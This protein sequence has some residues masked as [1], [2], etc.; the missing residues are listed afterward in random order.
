MAQYR[1]VY[2]VMRLEKGFKIF[3]F[4]LR[5]RAGQEMFESKLWWMDR[6]EWS[7]C[8]IWPLF[9]RFSS[10]FL[11]PFYDPAHAIYYDPHTWIYFPND[12][13]QWKCV[14]G[15]RGHAIVCDNWLSVN[16]YFIFPEIF[17]CNPFWLLWFL[18]WKHLVS[19]LMSWISLYRLRSNEYNNKQWYHTEKWNSRWRSTLPIP[20]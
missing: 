19:N 3:S 1:A 15:R 4:W 5:G 7:P 8:A 10:D 13:F 14:R 11:W 20:V 16:A 18:W 2:Q 9:F 17:S 6:V 12:T